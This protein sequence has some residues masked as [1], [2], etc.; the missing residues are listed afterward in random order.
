[1]AKPFPKLKP[2]Q[3]ILQA[4]ARQQ[5]GAL[6]AYGCRSYP[7]PGPGFDGLRV[8]FLFSM[9]SIENDDAPVWIAAPEYL[10]AVDAETARVE[11]L[12]QFDPAEAGLAAGWLGQDHSLSRRAQPDFT[13]QERAMMAEFDTVLPWLASG[14]RPV[15]EDAAEAAGRLAARF[16][17][18]AEAPLLPYYREFGAWFFGWLGEVRR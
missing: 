18:L 16:Q 17:F 4:A 12:R 3:R 8:R 7:I 10:V 1:M 13:A 6:R 14:A 2:M 5:Q 15:R 9:V 11:E